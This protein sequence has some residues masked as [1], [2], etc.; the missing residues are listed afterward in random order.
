MKDEKINKITTGI[1]NKYFPKNQDAINYYVL[2]NNLDE[3]LKELKITQKLNEMELR[4]LTYVIK[5][6]LNNQKRHLD[7]IC[8][9]NTIVDLVN[10]Y[11]K[12][13]DTSILHITTFVE[14]YLFLQNKKYER[15]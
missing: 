12:T 1:L 7:T 10:E 11:T 3:L 9:I 8:F 4:L 5:E 2:T 6:A 15:E 14:H 13:E